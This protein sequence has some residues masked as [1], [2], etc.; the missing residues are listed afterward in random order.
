MYICARILSRDVNSHDA[1][2][3]GKALATLA[4]QL[5]RNVCDTACSGLDREKNKNYSR[6]AALCRRLTADWLRLGAVKT[7]AI[8]ATDE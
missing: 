2:R 6:L 3:M 1:E 4:L 7:V 8:G 5:A